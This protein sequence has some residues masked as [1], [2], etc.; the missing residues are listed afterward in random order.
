VQHLISQ[1]VAAAQAPAAAAPAQQVAAEAVDGFLATISPQSLE[2]LSYF[3]PEAPHKLNTYAVSIENALLESLEHQQRQAGQLQELGAW[4]QDALSVLQAASIEREAM[5]AILT[6]PDQLSDYVTKAF[7]P[8]GPWPTQTP[9]EQAR[10]SLEAGL[11]TPDTTRLVAS[12]EAD[13]FM[14]PE[15][16]RAWSQ[17]TGAPQAPA[18]PQA[19]VQ[20]PRFAGAPAGYRPALPMPNPNGAPAANPG[21]VF[22]AFRRAMAESPQ[23]AWMVLDAAG[24]DVLRTKVI[25]VDS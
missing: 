14:N 19:Q 10:A 20:D 7:G 15:F 4:V 24:P 8:E 12:G 17:A 3:G 2:V 18:Y 21:D 11:V 25:A 13:P 5:S 9:G 22:N 23:T 1:S 16:A 6:N